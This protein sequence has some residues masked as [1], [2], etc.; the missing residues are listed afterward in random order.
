[1]KYLRALINA[2]GFT[3]AIMW[4]IWAIAAPLQWYFPKWLD[5]S[6]EWTWPIK[7]K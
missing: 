5:K 3:L 6:W 4:C 7:T 1:M 2:L